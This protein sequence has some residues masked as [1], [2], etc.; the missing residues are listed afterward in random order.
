MYTKLPHE[1]DLLH[2]I[3]SVEELHN[4]LLGEPTHC[5]A[6]EWELCELAEQFNIPLPEGYESPLKPGFPTI[7][8]I[9][10]NGTYITYQPAYEERHK[11]QRMSAIGEMY[12]I[13]LTTALPATLRGEHVGNYTAWLAKDNKGVTIIKIVPCEGTGSYWTYYLQTLLN[14]DDWGAG[15]PTDRLCIDMGQ[16]WEVTNM[17]MLYREIINEKINCL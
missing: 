6:D 9:D 1:F 2:D 11:Y 16:S 3:K 13:Q 7:I 4:I 12:M 8:W 17:L 14:L 15:K 10:D 5:D